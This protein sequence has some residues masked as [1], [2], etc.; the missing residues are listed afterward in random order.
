MEHNMRFT[1]RGS[2]MRVNLIATQNI[3]LCISIW[4]TRNRASHYIQKSLSLRSHH[5][6][7]KF[8]VKSPA[9]VPSHK[10]ILPPSHVKLGI[11]KKFV[12]SLDITDILLSSEATFSFNS[13]LS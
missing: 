4:D 8:N 7:G 5:E 10:I 12:K 9:M 1:S 13:V 11:F 6:V 3:F 2:Y